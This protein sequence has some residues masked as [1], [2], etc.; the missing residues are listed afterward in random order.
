MKL[1]QTFVALRYLAG[2]L[3]VNLAFALVCF[4]QQASSQN[5]SGQTPAQATPLPDYPKTRIDA[6]VMEWTRAKN[7][8]KEYLD[9]MPEDGM[10]FKPTPDVRTFAEQMLHLSNANYF[11]AARFLGATN[12]MQGKN[13]EKMDEL[14]SK[15]ALTKT[16]MES[17]DF[18]ISTIKGLSDAKLD[19]RVE[20][21]KM[22]RPRA[23]AL[24]GAF[25][26][27]THH[28]GQTTVYL[29]LKGVTPPAEKLF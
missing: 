6:L 16:V 28:R 10:N 11:F 25:E 21:F 12:P 26:H 24:A 8:T 15:A 29:R 22:N 3:A 4:A 20:V 14:K 23:V 19:E 17:Y 7:Y 2:M 13:L 5:P 18:M 1:K 9:A 27:Q